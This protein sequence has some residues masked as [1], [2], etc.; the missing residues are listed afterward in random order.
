[1]Y[2]EYNRQTEPAGGDS[3]A[4]MLERIRTAIG[5]EYNAIA[6][7]EVLMNQAENEKERHQIAEIREDEIRHYQIFSSVYQQLTGETFRPQQTERCPDTYREGLRHAVEDEQN[8][9]DFYLESGDLSPNPQVQ[10]LFYRISRDEQQHA[11][12][13]LYFFSLI[14]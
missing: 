10:S 12:W 6:C 3:Q 7:Y 2:D 11:V 8:T 1:M 4:Q 5:G 9:V 13:F 14:R